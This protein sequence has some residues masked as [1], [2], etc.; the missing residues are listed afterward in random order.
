VGSLR[1]QSNDRLGDEGTTVRFAYADPPYLG[2]SRKHYGDHP[3]H[4]VYDTV[5][6]HRQLID[7][8][9]AEFPD[10]WA[11]SMASKNLH[12]LLPLCPADVR[13]M[14]WVKPFTTFFPNVPVAWA[15]EPV[16]VRGGRKRPKEQPTVRDYVVANSPAIRGKGFTGRK[17]PE[18]CYWLFEVLGMEPTDELVDLFPGSGAVGEAFDAWRGQLRWSA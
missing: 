7:R 16:I 8:L 6:G 4:A 13:V 2:A 3:D 1:L 9:V 10:G 15:W 17:P 18:F 12:P 14:A 5:E 11:L